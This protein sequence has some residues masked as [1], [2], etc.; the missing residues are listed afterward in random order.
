ME[1]ILACIL[2]SHALSWDCFALAGFSLLVCL[3]GLAIPGDG[4]PNV[5]GFHWCVLHM[6]LASLNQAN[7]YLKYDIVVLCKFGL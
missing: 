7:A 2:N 5:D 1:M 6:I 4:I 3:P